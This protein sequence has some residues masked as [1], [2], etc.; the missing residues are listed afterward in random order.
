MKV[1]DASGAINLREGEI[2]G[3]L[4]S[5]PEV[6]GEVRDIQA[7][8]KFE[9]A[10][11]DGRIRLET[12]SDDAFDRVEHVAEKNGV[13]S[14]LSLADLSVLALAYEKKLPI[15]TDDYDIQNMCWLMG[16]GFETI[17][18][19][20]IK[21]PCT[22]KRKCNACGKEYSDDVEECPVCGSMHFSVQKIFHRKR[23]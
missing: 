22:W 20:G 21:E 14:L 3:N 6:A 11:A 9:T 1:L 17:I 7:R 10:V 15:I 8:I 18:R 2:D 5:V 23:D 13:L 16:L 19:P 12:P 4:L